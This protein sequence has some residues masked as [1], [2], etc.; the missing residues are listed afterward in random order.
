M[1]KKFLSI[2]AV[3]FLFLQMLPVPAQAADY[4]VVYDETNMLET[5]KLIRLGT[6][7]LPGFAEEFGIDLRVDVLTDVAGSED[8]TEVAEY[9]Y[10][11]YDYGCGDE[12]TGV[13]LTLYVYE[14]ETGYAMD[15]WGAGWV[16][17]TVGD[18]ELYDHVMNGLLY[19]D[20]NDYLNSGAWDGDLSEDAYALSVAVETF[21]NKMYSYYAPDRVPEG[22]DCVLPRSG[23]SHV[24]DTAGLIK[25]SAQDE[26]EEAAEALQTK[27]DFGVYIVTVDDF[28]DYSTNNVFHAALNIYNANNF[29]VGAEKNGL[30]LLL[31]MEDRDLNLMT[32]GPYGEYAFNDAGREYMTDFFVDDFGEDRWYDGFVEYLTWADRYLEKA[33]EGTPYSAENEPW[34]SFSRNFSIIVLVLLILAVPLIPAC[35]FQSILDKMMKSVEKGTEASAYV[36]QRLKLTKQDDKYTRTTKTRRYNPPEDK[37]DSGGGGSSGVTHERSGSASG[38]SRKF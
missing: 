32:N 7:T 28:R 16:L 29:G 26:L 17:Y 27:Y 9:L 23:R 1:R 31:S 6:E 13:S 15:G 10:E 4:G 30:L 22:G 38:T 18:E 35:I 21:V 12:K 20:I 3:L 36:S 11:E 34:D 19:S 14:D 33:E 37:S 24:F 25:E 5:D 2:L 8:L